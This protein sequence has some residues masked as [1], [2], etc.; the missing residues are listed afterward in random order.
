[1]T[2]EDNTSAV[3]TLPK[4][5]LSVRSGHLLLHSPTDQPISDIDMASITNV[6]V[7]ME[8]DW[9]AIILPI[10]LFAIA[11]ACKWYFSSS[12]LGWFLSVVVGIFGLIA[13]LG[14]KRPVLTV[15]TKD[16]QARIDIKD[17]LPEAEA[18]ALSLKQ[19]TN[20]H[21]A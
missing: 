6:S 15:V 12:S 11:G 20:S 17:T 7:R 14:L 3:I 18:F 9:A 21:Q 2:T 13:F 4:T 1:M 16:G 19:Q 8:T 5:K 10:G